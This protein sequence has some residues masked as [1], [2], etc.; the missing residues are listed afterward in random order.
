MDEKKPE[1]NAETKDI[2]I[3]DLRAVEEARKDIDQHAKAVAAAKRRIVHDHEDLI[4]QVRTVGNSFEDMVKS[5]QSNTGIRQ[6]LREVEGHQTLMRMVQGPLWELRQAGVLDPLSP[7]R[8]EFQKTQNLLANYQ[9]RFRLPEV[10]ETARLLSGMKLNPLLEGFKRQDEQMA[11]LRQRLESIRVPWLDAD[12]ALRSATA[13]AQIQ[14]IGEV[15]ARLPVYDD[16]TS[17]A[18]R[19]GLGDWQ[20]RITWPK[21]IFV[22]L[23]ARSKFYFERGYDPS[24]ADFPASAFQETIRIAGLRA[25]RP[26]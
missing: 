25:R 11:V 7:V 9:E 21:K 4:E 19:V 1:K 22:N 16:Q 3:V 2:S 12:N 24:L 18:L 5:I 15:M 23:E 20:D 26:R 6:L 14:G 17:S 13:A 8:K 10:A